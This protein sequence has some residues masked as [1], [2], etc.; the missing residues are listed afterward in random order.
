MLAALLMAA[1]SSAA[2]ETS[3]YRLCAGGGDH[4]ST[5][6][7]ARIPR[8]MV[9]SNKLVEILS[10]RRKRTEEEERR[11]AKQLIGARYAKV[12]KT[13]IVHF[14]IILQHQQKR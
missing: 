10:Q 9:D 14:P 12:C 11:K 6:K 4:H 1:A 13:S 3:D 5:V 7:C 2:A 8:E